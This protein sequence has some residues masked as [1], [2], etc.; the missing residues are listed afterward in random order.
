MEDAMP[1]LEELKKVVESATGIGRPTPREVRTLVR[2]RKPHAFRFRDDG[3]TP[4]NPRLPLVYYRTP[5]RL[6]ADFDPAAIFEVL[7][8]LQGWKSSWRDGPYPYVHFHA[9]THEVLGIARGQA[10]VRFGGA[11]GRR[12]TLKAGD[13]V[14]LPAGTGHGSLGSSKDLRVVGAYPATGTY[15]E[16]KPGE[17]D[18]A[19]AVAAVSRVPL[20]AQDPVYGRDGPLKSLWRPR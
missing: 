17:V 6:D 2:S 20:P 10:H 4:K 19:K 14:V 8:A 3:V 18:H 13:V 11:G 5:V 9:R 7:F 15:D 12:F 1:W 16:P